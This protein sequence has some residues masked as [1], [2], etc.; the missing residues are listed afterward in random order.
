M[1]AAVFKGLEPGNWLYF[2]QHAHSRESTYRQTGSRCQQNEG[3]SINVL[4]FCRSD[5]TCRFLY[6]LFL[7]LDANF[8]MKRKKV[9]NDER[10]PSLN[11]GWAYFVE[12]GP[13]KE[14]L[15]KHWD[16]KQD[17]R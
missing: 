17:V 14:H 10:D 13:Y 11:E 3:T 1:K 8:Q 4:L 12:E 5:A 6:A 9:S 16:Q 7:S 15:T 2:A